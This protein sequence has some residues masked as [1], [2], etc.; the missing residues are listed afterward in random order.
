MSLWCRQEGSGSVAREENEGTW[1]YRNKKG[2]LPHVV[3]LTFR[4]WVLGDTWDY[5]FSLLTHL[6]FRCFILLLTVQ[7]KTG[8]SL[9]LSSIVAILMQIT[10]ML[11]VSS[12]KEARLYFKIQC[13]YVSIKEM[14]A[15][16]APAGMFEFLS[17]KNENRPAKL[18]TFT[19]NVPLTAFP[20]PSP[21]GGSLGE[22]F[23]TLTLNTCRCAHFSYTA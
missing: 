11:L 12:S 4:E 18:Q 16:Q 23:R 14:I 6:G 7:W 21:R 10:A 15:E 19:V 13:S 3:N 17:V 20:F 1:W 22:G 9:P 2:G 8:P 5:A